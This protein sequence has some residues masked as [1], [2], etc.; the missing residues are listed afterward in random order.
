MGSILVPALWLDP[1]GR[2]V[3]IVPLLLLIV[4]S[5]AVLDER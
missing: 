5:L 1:L 4:F 3:K 2:L